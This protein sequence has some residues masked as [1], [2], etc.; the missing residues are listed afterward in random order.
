MA[1]Q[2]KKK[3]LDFNIFQDVQKNMKPEQAAIHQSSRDNIDPQ[4]TNAQKVKNPCV[5]HP[6]NHMEYICHTER[7]GICSECLFEHY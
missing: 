5:K 7:I 3:T 4:P 1:E 6:Y 2:A